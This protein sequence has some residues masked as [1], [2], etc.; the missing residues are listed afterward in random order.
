MNKESDGD[1]CCLDSLFWFILPPLVGS[2]FVDCTLYILPPNTEVLKEIIMEVEVQ[3]SGKISDVGRK[4]LT[5]KM[6]SS[7]DG[8]KPLPD[9]MQ[10]EYIHKIIFH[11]GDRKKAYE[12]VFH[13]NTSAP[14]YSGRAPYRFFER[15]GFVKRY[16]YLMEQAMFSAGLD[17]KTLLLKT[18]AMLEKAVASN[19]VRDFTTLVDTVLKLQVDENKY[20]ISAPKKVVPTEEDL[21]PVK[22]LMESLNE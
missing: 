17:K 4:S 5:G 21:A 10:E 22:E 8:T 16:K 18:A 7:Y 3:N 11:M 12:E 20:A 13:P 15:K 1:Q 14:N 9:P 2:T 19:K 6:P